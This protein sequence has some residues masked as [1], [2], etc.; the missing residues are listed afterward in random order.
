M[1][2]SS[3]TVRMLSGGLIA[4]ASGKKKP[5]SKTYSKVF[6]PEGLEESISGLREFGS[7]LLEGL[8][9]GAPGVSLAAQER[10]VPTEFLTKLAQGKL[11]PEEKASIEAQLAAVG[12]GGERARAG[13]AQTAR[14]QSTARGLFSSRGAIAEEA[15][16]LAGVDLFEAQ[17]RAGILGQQALMQRQGI[18]QGS[19]LLSG[20]EAQREQSAL[21]RGQFG[22]S[23]LDQ[24]QRM[25]LAQQTLAA[26]SLQQAGALAGIT[27]S[28]SKT[29][30]S[31]GMGQG[32]GSILGGTVGFITG[33]PGGA[34]AGAQAGGQVG[35]M[36]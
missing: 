25:R 7:G 36:F 29:Y 31:S 1:S 4:G 35:S 34:F 5:V 24:A 17:Q 32:I 22:L 12:V 6:D 18:L 10:L 8:G 21:S 9:D 15:A 11:T 13:I 23:A 33:G 28:S 14:G 26:Q 20:L 16:G 19:Q 2:G 27:E 3:K 30:G